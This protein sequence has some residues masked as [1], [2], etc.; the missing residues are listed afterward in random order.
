M[1]TFAGIGFALETGWLKSILFDSLNSVFVEGSPKRT[2]YMDLLRTPT[3]VQERSNRH[4]AGK[5]RSE[6]PEG[7]SGATE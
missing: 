4:D 7:N 5:F 2:R 3:R 1:H 6:I